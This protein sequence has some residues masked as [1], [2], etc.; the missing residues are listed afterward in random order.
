[1]CFMSFL[2]Y[3]DPFVEFGK[4][5]WPFQETLTRASHLQKWRPTRIVMNFEH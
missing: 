1:M 3:G 4:S 2:P 5:D